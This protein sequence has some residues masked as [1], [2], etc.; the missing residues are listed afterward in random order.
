[1]RRYYGLI[2]TND[3]RL[4]IIKTCHSTQVLAE[5]E[6]DWQFG[7]TLLLALEVEGPSL[8]GFLNGELR[9]ETND[10]EHTF[11]AGGIALICEQG[12]TATQRVKIQPV[13]GNNQ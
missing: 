4:Q 6:L 3:H 2:V 9:L 12:R 1:M 5:V 11:E 7:D 8:R 13:P 10:K